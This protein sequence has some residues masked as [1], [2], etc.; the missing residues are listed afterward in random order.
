MP[1][2]LRM[3]GNV[4]DLAGFII[5]P[6]Q[7]TGFNNTAFPLNATNNGTATTGPIFDLSYAGYVSIASNCTQPCRVWPIV[8]DEND[9]PLTVVDGVG[10]ISFT[11]QPGLQIQ[12]ANSPVGLTHVGRVA[13]A[14]YG[15]AAAGN[16][17][18][19]LLCKSRF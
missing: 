18:I 6:P 1:N 8:M 13:L 4:N 19:R 15:P 7:V 16:A 2:F 11:C 5:V 12:D 3:F 14:V 9:N 10:S 17:T